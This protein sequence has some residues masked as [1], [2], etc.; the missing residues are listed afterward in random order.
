MVEQVAIAGGW[1]P[2][3]FYEGPRRTTNINKNLDNAASDGAAEMGR[4]L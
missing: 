4:Q 3:P 1:V 2:E